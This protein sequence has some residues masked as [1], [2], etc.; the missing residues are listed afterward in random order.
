MRTQLL[1]LL[2]RAGSNFPTISLPFRKSLRRF[3]WLE[4]YDR[5]LSFPPS[6]LSD[7]LYLCRRLQ[8]DPSSLAGPSDQ[9]L[10]GTLSTRATVTARCHINRPTRQN[11]R[12]ACPFPPRQSAPETTYSTPPSIVHTDRRNQVSSPS[13]LRQQLP[14]VA[15]PP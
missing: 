15:A 6:L 5:R 9:E 13:C 7:Q 11:N 1:Q 8:Y 4:V 3:C 12:S 10:D 14:H 2:D